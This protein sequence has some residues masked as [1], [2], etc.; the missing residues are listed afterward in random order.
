MVETWFDNDPI[1]QN[2]IG[3]T[4]FD[5]SI[6]PDV[7]CPRKLKLWGG[8]HS[9]IGE[10]GGYHIVATTT[11]QKVSLDPDVLDPSACL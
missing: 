8:M 6:T 4:F 9:V 1:L 3:K 2:R 5:F 11:L 10:C 7:F